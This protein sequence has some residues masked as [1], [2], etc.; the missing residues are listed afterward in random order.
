[1]AQLHRIAPCLWFDSQAEE[2]A[3]FYAGIFPNS[4]IGLIT[5]Y[6]E[7]G[8]EHHGRPAGSVLTVS[9]TLDGQE[10]VALNGG[11]VFQFNPA[12]SLMVNCDTQAEIDHYWARLGEGGDPNAQQCGWLADRYGVSWQIAPRMWAELYTSPNQAGAKRAMQAMFGMK[13]LDIARL[14][15][16]FDGQA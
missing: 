8:F 9:F 4:A 11:P 3:R 14:Q 15:A 1:M 16:A 7:V 6:S 5:R 12:V 13:K 2:A 10:M